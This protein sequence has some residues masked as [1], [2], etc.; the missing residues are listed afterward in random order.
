[1][2]HSLWST[3]STSG[4]VRYTRGLTQT[5]YEALEARI[6]VQ[7]LVIVSWKSASNALMLVVVSSV[8]IRTR[9]VLLTVR[10]L[11]VWV[12]MLDI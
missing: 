3:S 8:I 4:R 12:G 10:V 7:L 9:R 11:T 2:V 5:T 6:T 1:M